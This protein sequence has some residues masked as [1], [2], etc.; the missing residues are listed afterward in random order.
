MKIK[1]EKIASSNKKK[2]CVPCSKSVKLMT[3]DAWSIH[4][5]GNAHSKNLG[6]KASRGNSRVPRYIAPQNATRVESNST[7]KNGFTSFSFE[8]ISY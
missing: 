7:S 1:S 3:S 5:K 4:V 8:F 2:W 6:K